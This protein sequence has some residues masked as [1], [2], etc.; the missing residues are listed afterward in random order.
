[1]YSKPVN[2]WPDAYNT[3]IKNHE[4][5]SVKG[6]HAE[7]SLFFTEFL[8]QMSG[9]SKPI[10]VMVDTQLQQKLSAN[11]KK[12][13]PIVDTVVT[14]GRNSIAFRGSRDDSQYHP[15]VGGFCKKGVGNFI[16]FLNYGV[17]RGDEE[18][19]NHLLNCQKNAS[20]ISKTTQN[21]LISCCGRVIS[22]EL[23]ADIKKA[24]YISIIADECSDS[25]M[26]EHLSLVIRFVDENYNI[27]EE[28][29]RFIH[30]SEGLSGQAL[31]NE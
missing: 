14:L 17:R 12:L 4:S 11:R 13:I 18:L 2:Y 23:L 16:D 7:T 25:S 27:R 1:M 20:Y 28:F 3:F 19:K 30:C 10:N 29:L 22:D 8:N 9:V 15:P 21:E 5:S 6:L 31:F 24:D 26:K